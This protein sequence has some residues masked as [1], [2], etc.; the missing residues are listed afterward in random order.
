MLKE[1][2]G[3]GVSMESRVV[4]FALLLVLSGGGPAV[5]SIEPG[6]FPMVPVP[7]DAGSAPLAGDL[8]Q[9]GFVGGDDLDIVR[10][11][12]GQSVTAG[13]L[14]HGD[15]SGDGF[16]GGDDLDAV[17]GDWGKSGPTGPPPSHTPEPSTL[18][19][20]SLLGTIALTV[21]W[22]RRRQAA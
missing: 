11:F 8:N 19:I 20:W 1:S 7:P 15:C 13:D 4:A 16:V 14:L 9:D 6:E 18:I 2:Q 17:R 5:G 21:R 22:W 12:W 3:K 10:S